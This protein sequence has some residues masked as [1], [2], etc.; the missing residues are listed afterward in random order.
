MRRIDWRLCFIADSEAAGGR[1]ILPLI[2]D[3]VEGGA[4]LVQLRG[5]KWTSRKFL[6]LGVQAV[7]F[8]RAEKIPLIINDRL[9][10]ALACEADG[11]HLGQDDLPIHYARKLLGK[12][13]MIGISTSTLEEAEEAEKAGADYVGA[14]PVF[15]TLSKRDIGPLLGLEG[16][17][18]IREKVKIPIL[19]IGG[20]TAGNVGEVISAGADGVAVISAIAAAANPK[21][22]A[23]EIIESIKK[24]TGRGRGD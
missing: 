3:A 22:A 13:R 4:T 17:R 12:N 11:V 21:K 8:L 14:G 1:E 9:D 10:I 2:V 7:R 6:E 23:A 19:A 18:A 15:G 24:H 16:L 20:L 5:K